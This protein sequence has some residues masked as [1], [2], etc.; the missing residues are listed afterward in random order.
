MY[1]LKFS[2]KTATVLQKNCIKWHN[3]GF[4]INVC[5]GQVHTHVG[6][7]RII[8]SVYIHYS[9]KLDWTGFSCSVPGLCFTVLPL[10]GMLGSCIV[11]FI[12]AALYEGLKV[13]REILLK[14]ALT[15]EPISVPSS[16]VHIVQP[17]H[18]FRSVSPFHW[19]CVTHNTEGF[20]FF[21]ITHMALKSTS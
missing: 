21:D 8:Q 13:G 14:R 11:I 2:L 15:N 20:L 1:S 7:V 6:Q 16:D 5:P 4:T 3:P 17:A 10:A 12:M 9:S 19:S 18:S